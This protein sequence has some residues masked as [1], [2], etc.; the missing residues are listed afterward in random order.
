MRSNQAKMP[1]TILVLRLIAESPANG[2][3]FFQAA[4][5]GIEDEPDKTDDQHGG[6]HQVVTLA[7]VARIDDQVAEAGIDGDH[8]GG[9]HYEPGDAKGEAQAD[10]DFWQGGRENHLGKK[11]EGPEAEVAAGEAEDG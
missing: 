6:H 5:A 3:D 11:A 9:Y 10:D 4:E 1:K 2:F 8:L 7:R